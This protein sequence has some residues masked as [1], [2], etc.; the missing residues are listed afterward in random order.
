MSAL[1]H[2]APPPLVPEKYDSWKK[3]MKLWEMATSVEK[4]KR[5]PTVFLS[6][7]GKAREA[8]LEMDLEKLDAEEGMKA[9]YEKLDSLF[10]T[11]KN[12]AALMAYES[13]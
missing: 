12:R 6:L 4:K 10:K 3:E 8:V 5:A 11:D 2:L 13:F 1:R 9:L 7:T